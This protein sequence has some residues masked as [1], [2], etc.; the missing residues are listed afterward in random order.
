MSV[1]QAAGIALL[2]AAQGGCDVAEYTPNEVKLSVTGDGAADKGQMQLMIGRLL[3][4]IDRRRRPTPPTR[5]ASLSL[6]CATESSTCARPPVLDFVRGTVEDITDDAAVI[7]VGGVGVRVE[8]PTADLATPQRRGDGPHR[9]AD[10]RRGGARLRVR[11]TNTV[12]SSSVRSHP[13]AVSVRRSRSRSCRSIRSTALERAIATGDA[14]ALALVTGVGK[15]TAG[16]IVL[17]LRDKLGVDRRAG[18]RRDGLGARRGPRGAEG[19]RLLRAGDPGAS[20]ADASVRRRRPDVVASRASK[21][22]GGAEPAGVE[23]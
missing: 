15:K 9:A 22:L 8:M 6:I 14:D 16:R 11:V 1:G 18:H 2:V 10:P 4:S 21:A 17:E 12:G 23:R 20:L 7:G 19:P 5:S 3:G 13:S